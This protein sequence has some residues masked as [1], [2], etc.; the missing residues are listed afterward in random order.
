MMRSTDV[1]DKKSRVP[2]V[3]KIA[4]IIS[5]LALILFTRR[6]VDSVLSVTGE[7]VRRYDI[8]LGE[9]TVQMDHVMSQ[10][11]YGYSLNIRTLPDKHSEFKAL[12]EYTENAYYASVLSGSGLDDVSVMK[13][14]KM[15]ELRGSV[16]R[17]AYAADQVDQMLS[18]E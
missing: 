13:K 5:G 10:V 12:C 9:K 18:G 4:V 2:F 1:Q 11:Y 7:A 16:G 8:Y 15:E 3:M 17:Y 14:K 6:T